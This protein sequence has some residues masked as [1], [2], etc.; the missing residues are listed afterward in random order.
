MAIGDRTGISTGVPPL[1]AVLPLALLLL[2][3]LSVAVVVTVLVTITLPL[4]G[5]V[6]LRVKPTVCPAASVP[7]KPVT[8]TTPVPLS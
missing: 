3:L 4:V 7:G 1:I 2:G 8:V 6:Y 5:A